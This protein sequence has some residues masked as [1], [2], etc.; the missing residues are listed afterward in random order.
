MEELVL[1]DVLEEHLEELD[2]LWATR[3]HALFSPDF[4]PL[5]LGRLEERMEAHLDGLRE[6]DGPGIAVCEAAL[7]GDDWSLRAAGAWGLLHRPEP[8]VTPVVSAIEAADGPMA[9]GL[10]WALRHSDPAHWRV[11]ASRSG[12]SRPAYSEA[13]WLDAL[14]FHDRRVPGE[15]MP[16]LLFHE[17]GAV[18]ALAWGIRMRCGPA[19]EANEMQRA[20]EDEDATV[21]GAV[22]VAAARW[23]QRSVLE[24]AR[25][26]ADR[27]G[28]RDAEATRWLGGL[29]SRD[30][31]QRLERASSKPPISAAALAA[32][33][34]LGDVRGVALLL[35]ALEDAASGPAAGAA[36]TALT[37]E[38]LGLV[39]RPGKDE[40]IDVPD[41]EEANRFWTKQARRFKEGHRY[42]MGRAIET[43]SIGEVLSSIDLEGARDAYLRARLD[44]ADK[45]PDIE[46]ERLARERGNEL[47]R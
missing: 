19:P 45:T 37:G 20:V 25:L 46:L 18:R 32:I 2:F 21:R 40:P 39:E 36:F 26:A 28:E 3:A 5:H 31:L 42:R 23:G 22:L 10:R 47:T 7:T 4:R 9:L 44:S 13:I 24:T 38:P 16:S 43:M 41:A 12:P 8:R 17:D 35:A 34:A 30:D 33:G 29:G 6:G 1:Q 27:G 15:R 14:A 11:A